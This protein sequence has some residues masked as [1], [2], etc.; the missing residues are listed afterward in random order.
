MKSIETKGR[1]TGELAISTQG[2]ILKGHLG[3]ICQ[4]HK[5]QA[6]KR[7]GSGYE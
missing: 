7:M 5:A 3:R 2:E 6:D 4:V 1:I